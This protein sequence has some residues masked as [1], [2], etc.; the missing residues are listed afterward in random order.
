MLQEIIN[1][2]NYHWTSYAIPQLVCSIYFA[3]MGIFILF[4]NPR[5]KINISFFFSCASFF[6]WQFGVLMIFL[7]RT[8]PVAAFWSRFIGVGV[9]YICTTLYIFGINFLRIRNTWFTYFSIA[10]STIFAFLCTNTYLI[11]DV[12]KLHFYGYNFTRG[13]LHPIFLLFFFSVV[14]RFWYLMF[15]E[16]KKA[17]EGVN[18]IRFAQIKYTLLA[19]SLLICASID[20]LPMYIPYH[21]Y[22]FGDIFVFSFTN[23]IAYTII[24]HRLM[25]VDIVIRRGIMGIVILALALFVHT[26]IITITQRYIGYILSSF[27]SMGIIIAL[28]FYGPVRNIF[29]QV[30]D[31]FIYR[32]RYD[33]QGVLKQ[34]T[35]ALVSI[36]Q[37]DNLLDYIV[38]LIVQ[39]FDTKKV[40]LFL[41]RN[42]GSE[43]TIAASYGLKEEITGRFRLNC[44]NGIVKWLSEKKTVFVKEE[45]EISLPG[46]EFNRIYGD[47]GS[48]GAEVIIPIFYKDKLKGILN[49]GHKGSGVIY[50][51]QD[52]DILD[53]LADSSAIA[54][55]NASVYEEAITDGLT[56]LYHHKYFLTRL[57]EELARSRRYMYP[58]SL[59]MLDIDYFKTFNDKYGHLAGDEVLKGVAS[60]IKKNLRETDIIARYGGEEFVVLLPQ[61]ALKGAETAGARLLAKVVSE[62]AVQIA[63]RIRSNVELNKF[64]VLDQHLKITISL[65]VTSFEGHGEMD[66]E[67][68]ISRADKALY[69][70]KELGRNKIETY[71]NM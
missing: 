38:K 62:G 44:K 7:S 19:Y 53:S 24:R 64:V 10:V 27:V 56:K 20:Y 30:T 52:M 1:L 18:S 31:K 23:I 13:K 6:V 42:E 17:S 21:L 36:L 45:K 50:N 69:K 41:A 55:E 11:L 14:A 60:L 4:N 70:A 63:E 12:P 57:K 25:D 71:E 59:I 68:F 58:L 2:N 51:Q 28:F 15:R 65:G 48:I 26:I 61:T 49:L 39:N 33:Y 32:G 5:S 54:I 3:V 16:Y 37:L 67:E 66:A 46:E 22:P 47:L 34:A 8:E 35:K 43:Y 29:Q 40:S 9:V